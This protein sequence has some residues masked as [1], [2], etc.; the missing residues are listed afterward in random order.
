MTQKKQIVKTL[1]LKEISGVTVPAQSGALVTIMKSDHSPVIETI[2]K[3][4]STNDGAVSFNAFLADEAESRRK[5][6]AQEAVWP[7]LNA[8]RD[9]VCSIV[10]D[11][12]LSSDDR[13]GKI[14]ESVAQFI[15]AMQ[16]PDIDGNT[17]DIEKLFTTVIAKEHNDMSE[18]LKKANEALA[19]QV[20]ELTKKLDEAATLAKFSDAEKAYIAKADKDA[21]E[22]FKAASEDERK[23]TLEKAASE[24]AIFKSVDGVEIRKSDVGPVMFEILKGQD[25][26]LAATQAELTKAREATRTVELTKAAEADYGNLPGTSAEK[27]AVLK[28]MDKM[29]DAERGTLTAMLKAAQAGLAGAF[30][31]HGTAAATV[32]L[33]KAAKV[34]T[35]AKAYQEQHPGTSIE[36]AK[37]AVLN[38]HPDLYE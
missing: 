17:D 34:E 35:L 2:A 15:V 31:E 19:A 14:A 22:K 16:S 25:A 26:R 8:L 36:V 3:Y 28:A 11:G 6:E 21:A 9:S 29:G 23:K 37:T 32:D 24:D 30:V 27:V 38:S 4:L 13:Q 10:A 18:E 12:S 7:L 33:A 1:T 5:W 20:A